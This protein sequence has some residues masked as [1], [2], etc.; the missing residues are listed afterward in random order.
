[1]CRRVTKRY[2]TCGKQQRATTTPITCVSQVRN[3][4]GELVDCKENRGETLVAVGQ[5]CP[6]CG[7][8]GYD[9]LNGGLPGA[10]SCAENKRAHAEWLATQQ[11][12]QE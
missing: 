5:Y 11:Q 2:Y 10:P 9:R 12:N 1:M 6:S 3:G 7:G 8:L 4:T